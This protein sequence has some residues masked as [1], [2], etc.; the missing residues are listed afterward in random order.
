M[1]YSQAWNIWFLNDR[2]DESTLST[3]RNTHQFGFTQQFSAFGQQGNR[4][5]LL[6]KWTEFYMPEAEISH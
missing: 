4:I 1:Y 3:T 5:F 2:T 6:V